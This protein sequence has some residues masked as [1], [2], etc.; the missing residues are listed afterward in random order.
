MMDIEL[1][2]E[3]HMREESDDMLFNGMEL[4]DSVKQNIR[5]ATVDKKSRR[6]MLPKAWLAGAAAMVAAVVI[7]AGLPSL[8]ESAVPTP[9]ENS[10]GTVQPETGGTGAASSEL[11]QLNTTSFGT[12]EEAKAAFGAGVLV[13]AVAKEGMELAE[14]VGV[15]MEGEPLR[16]LNFTYRL[17]DKTI[18]FSA[19]RM[20]AAYPADLFTPAKVGGVDGFIFEQAEYTELYWMVDGIQYGV[21]GPISGDEAM[22]IAESVKP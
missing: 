7:I 10:V 1:K 12:A 22:K 5:K 2:L 19:S 11:S 21:S 15:G 3:K 17:G 6:F 13:P 8:Q 20:P 18:T 9:T 14:I 4:S 16:D